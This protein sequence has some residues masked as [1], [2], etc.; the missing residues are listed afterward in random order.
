VSA[1]VVDEAHIDL[2]ADVARRGPGQWHGGPGGTWSFPQYVIDRYP[3]GPEGYLDE[4]HVGRLLLAQNV[5]SVAYRYPNEPATELPGPLPTPEADAYTFTRLPYHLTAVEALAAIACWRYQ[6]CED[7]DHE[8]SP[9]WQFVNELESALIR[10][11]P[12][13]QDAPW[14]WSTD[15]VTERL[16]PKRPAVRS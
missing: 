7:P 5:K 3:V 2:L 9:A 4:T 14:C 6:S 12:G 16:N 11:L 15:T 1:F 10:C 8:R 13:Y